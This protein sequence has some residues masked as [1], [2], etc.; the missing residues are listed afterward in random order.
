[1]LPFVERQVVYALASA[2]TTLIAWWALGRSP[3]LAA[4]PRL[5]MAAAAVALAIPTALY[6]VA[7]RLLDH[8]HSTYQFIGIAHGFYV[9]TLW[10]PLV[11]LISARRLRRR[12]GGRVD[13][14]LAAACMGLIGVG[15]Y[16]LFVEPNRLVVEQHELEIAGWPAA[17]PPLRVVHVS[18]LQ[19]V[20]PCARNR[21]AVELINALEPDLVVVTGDY[22]A[23]PFGQD[24]VLIEEARTF[25]GGLEPRLTTVC[26]A[27]HSE[28]E[29]MRQRIFEGLDVTYLYNGETELEL[30]PGRRL[31]IFGLTALDADLEAF[32]PRAEPG[33][34]TL[35]A[36]HV[37]DV[38][39]ELEGLSVDLHLAGHTHGGQVALPFVGAPLTLSLLPR[40]YARG[41]HRF[42]D[43]WLNVNPGIGMEGH[44]APR[45]R[46]L[47]PPQIDVILLEG[48]GPPR[49]PAEGPSQF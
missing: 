29:S 24:E 8:W 9:G 25:L 10:L 14:P 4:S 33:L 31:R 42:G 21:R 48:S 22:V 19:T 37:P 46:F 43:H 32:E 40:R 47:C 1:M 49:P 3:R 35:F 45:I 30:G 39:T 41:L 44:H 34:V 36:S 27:G 16:A 18:D 11:A 28:P 26:V 38:T 23:G 15:V 17:A 5:R 7:V 13:V 6:V 20:G 2:V 12:S